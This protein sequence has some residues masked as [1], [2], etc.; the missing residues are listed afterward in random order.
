MDAED[1]II[2]V[3]FKEVN[4]LA[5]PAEGC[6]FWG[7]ICAAAK[8][9]GPKVDEEAPVE[10]G[11][12]CSAN[13]AIGVLIEFDSNEAQISFYRNKVFIDWHTCV[14]LEMLRSRF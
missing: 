9:I 13:D 11:E 6:P 10:Y 2:G 3:A 12:V 14:L 5:R 1:V 7:Y 4:L 8:K